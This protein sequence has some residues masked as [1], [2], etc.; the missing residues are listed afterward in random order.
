[1]GKIY[2]H[3][4]STSQ[5]QLVACYKADVATISDHTWCH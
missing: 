5:A 2:N 4:P 1:M 3:Q